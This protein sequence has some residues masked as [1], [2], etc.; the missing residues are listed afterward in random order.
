MFMKGLFITHDIST[1]GAATS[2]SLLLDSIKGEIECDL[3]YGITTFRKSINNNSIRKRFN[4]VPLNVYQMLLNIDYSVLNKNNNN[5]FKDNFKSK[6]AYINKTFIKN[7]YKNYDFCYLNSLT[8][9]NLTNIHKNTILQV[10][11]VYQGSML[12]SVKMDLEKAKGIIFIDK[13]TKNKFCKINVE[14]I[15]LNNP[16]DMKDIEDD[17]NED[18][19]FRELKMS[20]ETIFVMIGTLDEIKGTEYVIVEYLNSKIIGKAKLLI[21][22]EGDEKF[23]RYLKNKYD[24]PSVIFW[25]E[26][27]NIK[28]IY[29]YA[30]YLI[31]GDRIPCIGRTIYEG[32]YSGLGV[33]IPGERKDYDLNSRYSDNIYYYSTREKSA[34]KK[35][36]IELS[37]KKVINKSYTSNITE[38]KEKFMNFMSQMIEQK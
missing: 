17:E 37:S 11:E 38:Y 28:K 8:L 13:A 23:R 9:H 6:I 36:F 30:D 35:I 25:G 29:K 27:S 18:Q 14:Q 31:R 12:E 1:Y 16:F 32:L 5:S 15:I 21:V 3:I 20:K 26:E 4:N 7:K 33:I 2:M 19:R 24:N 34:L 22:G 10:R